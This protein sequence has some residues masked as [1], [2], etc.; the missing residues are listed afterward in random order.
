VFL[1]RSDSQFC[2]VIVIL[3][4][5]ARLF[6]FLVCVVVGQLF[7]YDVYQEQGNKIVGYYRPSSTEALSSHGYNAHKTKVKKDIPSSSNM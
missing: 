2:V 5:C 7:S 6:G 1:V 4:S 3:C